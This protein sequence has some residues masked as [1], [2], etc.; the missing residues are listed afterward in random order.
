[1]RA[2][3]PF[4]KKSAKQVTY[5]GD[6]IQ[7][8]IDIFGNLPEISE[9]IIK[10]EDLNGFSEMYKIYMGFL[11]NYVKQYCQ[12][13]FSSTDSD[14]EYFQNEWINVFYYVSL[15]IQCSL[16]PK[17]FPNSQSEMDKKLYE[18][19]ISL[20]KL[21]PKQFAIKQ[22]LENPSMIKLVSSELVKSDLE[23]SVQE[24]T[25][26]FINA[27]QIIC[28]GILARTGSAASGDDVLPVMVY[29]LVQAAPKRIY[30]SL[31]YFLKNNIF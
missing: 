5:S 3:L 23:N 9:L 15:H 1:L 28:S 8:F 14:F 2:L 19:A 27:Y 21:T 12:Y 17:I 11:Q 16:Y 29:S 31:K 4:K 18:K 30:Y 24:K 13:C 20:Q 26:C 25:Q 6:T 10:G 7:N 22:K